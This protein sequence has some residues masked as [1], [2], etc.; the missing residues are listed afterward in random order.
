[1][2]QPTRGKDMRHFFAALCAVVALAL[3]AAG[4]ARAEPTIDFYLP[5]GTHTPWGET[6]GRADTNTGILYSRAGQHVGHVESTGRMWFTLYGWGPQGYVSEQDILLTWHIT[7][8]MHGHVQSTRGLSAHT[9][10]GLIRGI[11]AHGI[12]AADGQANE[13]ALEEIA[14]ALTDAGALPLK[15]W[16]GTASFGYTSADGHTEIIVRLGGQLT[17]LFLPT[18]NGVRWYRLVG[19]AG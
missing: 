5:A 2:F 19:T 3:S 9:I 13:T 12:S 4:A 11:T 8:G 1:M 14:V 10:V 17:V 6:S 16:P 7:K 18:P 15:K